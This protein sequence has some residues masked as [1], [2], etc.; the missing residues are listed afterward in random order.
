MQ[1]CNCANGS[2]QFENGRPEDLIWIEAAKLVCAIDNHRGFRS[3]G[4]NIYFIPGTIT[5]ESCESQLEEGRTN[6]VYTYWKST[7]GEWQFYKKWYKPTPTDKPFKLTSV[8]REAADAAAKL[9]C[10]FMGYPGFS[11]GGK[12]LF[13]IPERF[14]AIACEDAL[15]AGVHNAV[16]TMLRSGSVSTQVDLS[17][18]EEYDWPMI[19]ND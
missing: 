18:V 12:N 10:E 19:T 5:E 8:S 6:K 17:P 14:S 16:Y 7:S 2:R 4:V 11:F 3:G 13:F 15:E 1:W 9:I